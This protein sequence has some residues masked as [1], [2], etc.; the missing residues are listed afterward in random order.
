MCRLFFGCLP[1]GGR[2][3][4]KTGGISQRGGGASFFLREKRSK[5]A[6]GGPRTPRQ[7]SHGRFGN[8]SRLE[9]RRGGGQRGFGVPPSGCRGTAL[10]GVWCRGIKDWARGKPKGGMP[11]FRK[12][13]LAAKAGKASLRGEG[14]FR[15]GAHLL[16]YRTPKSQ[17][18]AFHQGMMSAS[19]TTSKKE[20]KS[21]GGTPDPPPGKPWALREPRPSGNTPGWGR[22]GFGAPPTGCRGTA[23]MGGWCRGI[24]GAFV[25]AM[26]HFGVRVKA[27][28]FRVC[29]PF[30]LRH[31]SHY[32]RF[33][34]RVTVSPLMF[35]SLA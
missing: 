2:F 14:C 21:A 8:P 3:S 33:T 13:V 12:K 23:R 22:T 6:P 30:G 18:S 16:F 28:G 17:I 5:K 4:S 34:P 15:W 32:T 11:Y 19:P 24:K 7:A 27:E 29:L 1:V 10:M 26:E 35:H 20:Q 31:P 25:W 9:T